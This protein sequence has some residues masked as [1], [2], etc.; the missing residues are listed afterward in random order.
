MD[1]YQQPIRPYV[2]PSNGC[3]SVV[4]TVAIV[5]AVVFNIVTFSLA[6]YATVEMRRWHD[7][8]VKLTL[9]G[10][11]VPLGGGA[12]AHDGSDRRAGLFIGPPLRPCDLLGL[13]GFFWFHAA[14]FCKCP[15]FQ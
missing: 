3:S 2:T 14:T 10:N 8:D 13:Q 9:R 15:K 11:S 4:K 1:Y 5:A 6:V 7:G 12:Q